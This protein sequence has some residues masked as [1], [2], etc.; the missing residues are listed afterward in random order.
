MIKNLKIYSCFIS[1]SLFASN[2]FCMENNFLLNKFENYDLGE[3][4]NKLPKELIGEIIDI[5]FDG[6]AKPVISEHELIHKYKSF[7]KLR[8]INK[9]FKKLIESI[10][11]NF[12][13][14][15]ANLSQFNFKKLRESVIED[16]KLIK[17]KDS[18]DFLEN[19][20]NKFER[21]GFDLDTGIEILLAS[22]LSFTNYFK[23]L[24]KEIDSRTFFDLIFSNLDENYKNIFD[25]AIENSPELAHYLFKEIHVKYFITADK[26]L[27]PDFLNKIKSVKKNRE[28]RYN[29][30]IRIM[31]KKY[32]LKNFYCLLVV[33]P[34]VTIVSVFVFLFDQINIKYNINISDEDRKKFNSAV[35][36]ISS[37][38]FFLSLV[39][40]DSCDI[41]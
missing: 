34:F 13:K 18:S 14:K 28:N 9:S 41:I 39:V 16:Y 36:L 15:D 30:L 21:L 7:C 31:K 38:S 5:V 23:K 29:D 40:L 32:I 19:L 37:V 25:H 2:L 35:A 3:D 33:I 12:L 22:Q 20:E 27:I 6:L 8:L 1:I 17:N 26:G 10:I 11:F 24:N 4:F